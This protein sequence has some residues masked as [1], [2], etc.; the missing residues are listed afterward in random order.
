MHV[1]V[2]GV[3]L[4]CCMLITC[5]SRWE[6]GGGGPASVAQRLGGEGGGIET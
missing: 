5:D 1:G 6:R 2:V 4:S 3:P